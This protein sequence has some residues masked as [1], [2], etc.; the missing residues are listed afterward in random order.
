M[1]IR[2]LPPLLVN[3]IAA[4]E[5]IER[6]ASVVKELV[7][8]SLDAGATRIDIA[9]EDGGRELIR[10]SDN[11]SGIAAEDLPMAVA[12]HATSK[13]QS[14]EQ[15][16]AI[17]TLGFRGEAL[18]SI[19]SVSRL[20][21]TSRATIAERLAD[22]GWMIEVAGGHARAPSP[23][24][25]A[26]GTIVEVRDLFFNTPARRKFM[27]AAATEFGHISETVLRLAMANPQ[28][29]FSLTHGGRK[30]LDVPPQPPRLRCVELLGA[31]LDEALL[32]FEHVADTDADLPHTS[33]WGLAGLP[34]IARATSKFQYL[35]LN[36][37]A[38]RDRNLAHAIRE[39][40][41]GLTPSDRQPVAVIMLRMDPAA[42]DVN[43]HPTKSE[44]RF[45]HTSRVHSL[46]L[47]TLRQRLLGGDLTP[48]AQVTLAAG[49]VPSM[50]SGFSREDGDSP[51][52]RFS[53]SSSDFVDYF[54]QMAP[55]QRGFVYEQVKAAM[56]EARAADG[57][58]PL[59]AWSQAQDNASRPAPALREH[60]VLQV[61]Q[62]YLV[63]QDEHGIIIIDQHALHERVIFEELRQRVLGRQMESQ[64]LLMPAVAP[65]NA[66][67]QDLLAQ[68]QPL[69]E[70]IGIEAEPLGPGSIG[71][72]AFPTLLFERRVD[73]AEFITELL[74]RA[75]E[76]EFDL[77]TPT[78][79]EAAL[80][81]VL[82]MM[83]C[84]AAVK[85]GDQLAP[86]ELA[87]LL[88]K[89]EQ[90]ERASNCPHGRPTAIRL[91]LRDL[92]KQFKRT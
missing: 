28:A 35:F 50:F 23:A 1:A 22:S 54:K 58:T 8:N 90:V 2:A 31:E 10:I 14:A 65:A 60:G 63:T 17:A 18:A 48:S 41:R 67:R 62:S 11:G 33:I 36:G 3:Q 6:P 5:V 21:L 30:A 79:T 27:R 91:T 78:T 69:L 66:R 38:I 4:G 89:R 74:D 42:V 77:S 86:E 47:H 88:A 70:R 39:A 37:R 20:R 52:A 40:Y 24:A 68:L 16:E 61:H 83:A 92:E 7:E 34:T 71:V 56:D 73:P 75:E 12:P 55:T 87:A 72:Q 51:T 15:L 80:H 53:P 82:D 13:L 57:E 84:K 9:V 26:G 29:A 43:V 59:D 32:E 46:V 76:G 64:R 85:A 44:V 49:A 81:E 45:R 25:C 19:A